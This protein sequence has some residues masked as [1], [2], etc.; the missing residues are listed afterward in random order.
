[1][2]W[3][4]G[5]WRLIGP[6]DAERVTVAFIVTTHQLPCVFY[7]P[8]ASCKRLCPSVLTA[9]MSDEPLIVPVA[10]PSGSLY[11]ATIT[12]NGTAEDVIQAL[13]LNEGVTTD[14]LGDLQPFGWVLQQIH[15]ENNGRQWEEDE[16][17]A[18]GNG[19]RTDQRV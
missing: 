16:L 15:R 7:L 13:L 3:S 5:V 14:V 2:L 18:L 1:M 17:E 8:E 9:I 11:F 6:V 10:V 4:G 12:P 19:E